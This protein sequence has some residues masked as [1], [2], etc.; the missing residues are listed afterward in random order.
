VTNGS[1]R[2]AG[3]PTRGSSAVATASLGR[4]G[5]TAVGR[6][7]AKAVVVAEAVVEAAGGDFHLEPGVVEARS[8]AAFQS[9]V[10]TFRKQ[11]FQT[12][13]MGVGGDLFVPSGGHRYF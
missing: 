4:R 2:T 6:G 12:N 1:G 9:L 11:D 10:Y 7:G 8:V 13:H 3:R 5:L